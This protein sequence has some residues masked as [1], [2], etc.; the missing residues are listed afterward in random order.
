MHFRVIQLP[1]PPRDRVRRILKTLPAVFAGGNQIVYECFVF[2]RPL[3]FQTA[4]VVVEL[5]HGPGA[6]DDG[7]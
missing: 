4:H 2:V 6:D 3:D 1:P 5:L 7:G